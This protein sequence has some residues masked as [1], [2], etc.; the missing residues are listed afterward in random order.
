MFENMDRDQTIGDITQRSESEEFCYLP[1]DLIDPDP[2]QPRVVFDPGELEALAD[3]IRVRQVVQP[4]QVTPAEQGRYMII[5]GERRWRGSKLAEKHTIPAIIKRN[6]SD[7][8]REDMQLLSFFSRVDLNP[9]ELAKTLELMIS[10]RGDSAKAVSDELGVSESWIS[11]RRKILRLPED[12]QQLAM[13]GVVT[14]KAALNKLGSLPHDERQRKIEKIRA[15]EYNSS[16]LTK[17]N[18]KKDKPQENKDLAILHLEKLFS[19]Q[20]GVP[21]TI[22]HNA[23]KDTGTVRFTYSSL[24]QPN[25]LLGRLHT[26]HEV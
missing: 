26:S 1:L 3:T 20:T 12:V 14:D 24:D 9:V 8:E 2:A 6:V 7:S 10:K 4:I 13:D 23:N 17:S 21:F 19:E 22:Q 18:N 25:D 16:E 15:G 11:Q 5:D